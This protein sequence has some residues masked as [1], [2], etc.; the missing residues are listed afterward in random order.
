[1]IDRNA[2]CKQTALSGVDVDTVE[3][4]IGSYHEAPPAGTIPA[5]S[6]R[7]TRFC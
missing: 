1:M 4:H 2:G 6:D 7:R 3:A 5:Q